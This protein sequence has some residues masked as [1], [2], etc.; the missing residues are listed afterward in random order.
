MCQG[1]RAGSSARPLAQTSLVFTSSVKRRQRLEESDPLPQAPGFDK[2]LERLD[3]CVE[4][5][6]LSVDTRM[7]ALF[8]D[9]TH[10]DKQ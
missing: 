3:D 7:P 6:P 4:P 1:S 8:S 2:K 9:S 5:G 10:V